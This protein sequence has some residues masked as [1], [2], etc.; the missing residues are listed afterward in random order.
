ML[1]LI[2]TDNFESI[3]PVHV[4]VLFGRLFE[5]FDPDHDRELTET[6]LRG[7]ILGLGIERHN[8]Q[9]PDEEEL[10]HWMKE[11]D[12]SGD[13]QISYDEFLEG[14]KRWMKISIGSFK[15]KSASPS[16]NSSPSEHNVWDFEAQV[17]VRIQSINFQA[18]SFKI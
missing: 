1:C 13:G 12:V 16:D 10:T 15:R 17:R 3:Y 4:C 18:V 6:E 9:V 8:G 7:L 5:H 14:I 2:A 11:F